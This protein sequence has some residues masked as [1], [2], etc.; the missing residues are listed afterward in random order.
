MNEQLDNAKAQKEALEATAKATT[1]ADR[2][3][4]WAGL[5]RYL[6]AEAEHAQKAAEEEKA[7]SEEKGA[8]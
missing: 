8:R 7:A 4:L 3:R 6:E 5:N 1:S 2:A